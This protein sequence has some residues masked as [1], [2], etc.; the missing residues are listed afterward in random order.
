[1]LFPL[2]GLTKKQVRAI[3]ES[4]DSLAGLSVLTKSESM[5]VCFI[6]KRSMPSFLS[7][8]IDLIPGRSVVSCYYGIR[9]AT[10][11]R[12]TALN[13]NINVELHLTFQNL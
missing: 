7:E 2:G 8:Y 13:L 4:S 9:V 10:T 11:A 6:G 3:A 1:V 5:G 12:D